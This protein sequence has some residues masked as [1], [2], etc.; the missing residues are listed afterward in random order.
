MIESKIA[1]LIEKFAQSARNHYNATLVGDWRSANKEANNIKKIYK[2][3]QKMGIPA[4]EALLA[5]IDNEDVSVSAMA[6]AY[7]L[8]YAPDKSLSALKRLA[9]IPG[10][11]GFEAKQAIMRWKE[12]TWQID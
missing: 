6:A 1:L 10:L 3:L 11:I 5:Q 2:N 8:R 12:G 9:T 4:R 7:S